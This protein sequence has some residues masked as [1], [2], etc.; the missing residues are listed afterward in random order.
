MAS[1]CSD[2]CIPPACSHRAWH[3]R[4]GSPPMGDACR[5]DSGKPRAQSRPRSTDVPVV[6]SPQ[7]QPSVLARVRVCLARAPPWSKHVM[8]PLIRPVNCS[9]ENCMTVLRSRCPW[10]W[11]FRCLPR[12]VSSKG[13]S[14]T[15]ISPGEYQLIVD[16]NNRVDHIKPAEFF[17]TKAAYFP[18]GLAAA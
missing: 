18:T 15:P 2:R 13:M 3:D 10:R 8:A 16:G 9:V 6:P 14:G 5:G 1:P 7:L 17:T 12:G 4:R 11:S